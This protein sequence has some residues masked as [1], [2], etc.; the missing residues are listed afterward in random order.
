M[1]FQR[2]SNVLNPRR[3]LLWRFRAS[4][5]NYPWF[6][7][8][9]LF[10]I[11]FC[12][13]SATSCLQTLTAWWATSLPRFHHNSWIVR[14]ATI[15]Y[16]KIGRPCQ[17]W[18]RGWPDEAEEAS[19]MTKSEGN[20]SRRPQFWEVLQIAL[21]KFCCKRHNSLCLSTPWTSPIQCNSGD[22]YARKLVEWRRC[23]IDENR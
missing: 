20:C 10:V 5:H 8:F 9:N 19:G 6:S 12:N 21:K 23:Y 7:T 15:E 1:I 22:D 13:P 18:A 4:H 16:P 3:I 2:L 11:S 17:M 14:K